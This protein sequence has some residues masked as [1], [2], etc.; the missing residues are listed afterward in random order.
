MAIQ[1]SD[2]SRITVGSLMHGKTFRLYARHMN[3]LDDIFV[4]LNSMRPNDKIV[5]VKL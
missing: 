2:S 1:L 4:N 3:R 5:V